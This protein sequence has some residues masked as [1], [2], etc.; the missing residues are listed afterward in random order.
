MFCIEQKTVLYWGSY[1]TLLL[2]AL[3]SA[4]Q[5]HSLLKTSQPSQHKLHNS[6]YC[7]LD[8]Q[9]TQ[10][11]QSKHSI[12][13]IHILVDFDDGSINNRSGTSVAANFECIYEK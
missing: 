7:W 4:G 2:L 13:F 3:S 8:D 1:R 5:A 6:W 11:R 9:S 10:T 12:V